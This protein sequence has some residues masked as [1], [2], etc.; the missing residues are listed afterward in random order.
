MS[1]VQPL[2]DFVAFDE[3]LPTPVS[4]PECLHPARV[5]APVVD[6]RKCEGKAACAAVCPYDVF[7]IRHF[8][9]NELPQLGMRGTLKWWVNGGR[10][11]DVVRADQCHG[12]GLCVK[13]CP[14]DAI[15]LR[16]FDAAGT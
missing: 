4:T 6:A 11:A 14:E 8:E 5:F 9:R 3:M 1:P 13:A 12:C 10:Q 16:R 2:S 15:S 7:E